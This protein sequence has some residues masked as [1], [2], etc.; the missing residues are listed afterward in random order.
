MGI[1]AQISN[2][3][4]SAVSLSVTIEANTRRPGRSGRGACTC[5]P[6]IS[7][8]WGA[9]LLDLLALAVTLVCLPAGVVDQDMPAEP[10]E[11]RVCRE[12]AAGSPARGE[13]NRP[14][15][16]V[17]GQSLRLCSRDLPN[18]L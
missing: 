3:A 14:A 7:S 1:V 16:H 12:G 11:R 6:S 17:Y 4:E 8:P 5:R 18:A 2:M 9:V 13:Q 15:G 10:V